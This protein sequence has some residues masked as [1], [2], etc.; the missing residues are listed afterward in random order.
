[1][2]TH[3]PCQEVGVSRGTRFLR[4]PYMGAAST[5]SSRGFGDVRLE[6]GTMKVLIISAA[7]PP[8][9]AGE[10]DHTL[11]LSQHL[12]AR[13]LDIHIVTTKKHVIT[14][15]FPFTVHPIIENWTWSALPHLGRFV[16]R[17]SPQAILLIYS[18]WIY[19][20]HP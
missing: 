20:D 4:C 11:Y 10:A 12:A 7:F 2:Q 6:S 16:K 17:C 9:R 8:M 18:G 15:E 13:G 1:M 5:G 19:H 14:G 3:Y